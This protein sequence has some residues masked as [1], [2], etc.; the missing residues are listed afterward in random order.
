VLLVEGMRQLAE[1]DR[2]APQLPPLDARV[3]LRIARSELPNVVHPLTREALGLVEDYSTVGEIVDRCSF[4]DYQVLST[5]HTLSEREIIELSRVATPAPVLAA[6]EP[7]PLLQEGQARRL[8]EWMRGGR[9]AGLVA[10]NAKLLVVSSEPG[11]LQDFKRLIESV[12]GVEFSSSQADSQQ[13][14]TEH[15]LEVVGR[16]TV[17]DTTG[18]ELIHVPLD[19]KFAPLWPQAGYGAL[20]TLFLLSGSLSVAV[21]RVRSI[22]E[23]L[24]RLPR[25][26]LFHLIQYRKDE[27]I[28]AD[29]LRDN[30]A[31]IDEASTFLLPLES[32]KSPAVLLGRLLARVIP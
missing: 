12:P 4:P 21:R 23:A 17:D 10:R 25:S 13:E 14:V 7:R 19:P 27:R 15:D 3:S 5:L 18:I 8:V 28:T 6:G 9:A 20:G 31:M 26:R 2:V 22:T 11:A 29:D 30:L 16:I 1:W 24:R 32:G